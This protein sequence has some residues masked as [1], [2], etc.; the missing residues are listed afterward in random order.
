MNINGKP[1]DW[2]AEFKS[3]RAAGNPVA[4]VSIQN[5]KPPHE[6]ARSIFKEDRGLIEAHAKAWGF[7]R[8]SPLNARVITY[9]CP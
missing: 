3:A 8:V 2:A 1:I 9:V 7:R 4:S 5:V 6:T